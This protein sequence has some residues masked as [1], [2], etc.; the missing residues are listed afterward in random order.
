YSISIPFSLSLHDALPIYNTLILVTTIILLVILLSMAVALFTA[1]SISKPLHTVME[2]MRLIAMG[3]LSSPPLET[4][5]Q[6]EIGQLIKSDR[7]STRLN[8]SHVSIS[9][10]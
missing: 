1:N 3:D 5:L 4:K 7:K 10:A 9:Y 6:D 8:S 2:R